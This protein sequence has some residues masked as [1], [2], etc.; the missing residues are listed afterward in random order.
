[1]MAAA[2]E[3][4]Q[5][6]STSGFLL[7]YVRARRGAF[8]ALMLLVVAAA[9]CAVAV[10]YGMKLIVDAMAAPN[11]ST[12]PIWG[13]LGWFIGLIAIESALW[14]IAGM[15]GCRTVVATGVDIR[16]DLFARLTGQSMRFFG[17]H[18]AGSLGGRITA[19]AGASG[20]LY[21][22]LTWRIA[23]P[24]VDFL[25]AIAVFLTIDPPMA[26]A[27][28]AFVAVVAA[29]IVRV[30]HAGRPLHQAYAEQG[31][32]VNGELVDVV[33]NVWTVKAFSARQREHER[34]RAQFSHEAGAQQRSWIYLERVRAL[35]DG[36]LIVMA[37]SMLAWAI[38]LWRLE[39]ITPGDVVVISAVTFRILHGSRDLALALVDSSQQFGLIGEMLAVLGAPY[40]LADRPDARLLRPR[41]GCIELQDACFR[42]GTGRPILRH[43]NLRIEA[44]QRVGIVGASGAGKS[45]ILA[46]IQRLEDLD[47][48]TVLID[49]QPVRH[50][51]QDSLRAAIAVVPQDI[52][53]F[54]R[55]VLENIRYGRPDASDA[56][57]RR[58]AEQ[59]DCSEFI[60]ELENGYDTLV[61]ERGARLSGGQRQRVGIARAFLKDARILILDEA[62]SAL[63]SDAEREVHAALAR[64][65]EGRTVIAVAH[66]L[67]TLTS[68]ERV[69]VLD[70]GQILEDGAPAGLLAAEGVFAR[71]WQS[72]SVMS[73]DMMSPTPLSPLVHACSNADADA[74]N[75]DPPCE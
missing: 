47:S 67:S 63:D 55:S 2:A 27:L 17:E 16:L 62:T 53:L 7:R 65:I 30:G 9:A 13:L 45:T 26:A 50:L 31:A 8:T 61:G 15:L 18:L 43:L 29:L 10:Q 4:L 32:R 28:V 11:R 70:H 42:Y 38:H 6:A 51:T 21:G 41:G 64:L 24:I 48:G 34:L 22:N 60:A 58:A 72:Q 39:R 19:T 69:I 71:L 23:P 14:R 36:C 74:S 33:A 68:F 25:G 59:A 20:A 40:T 75:A 49:G 56:D 54:H 35:H 12:V 66:R 52:A 5:G 73:K 44:G 1:M 46:L 3:T 57:V 37:G